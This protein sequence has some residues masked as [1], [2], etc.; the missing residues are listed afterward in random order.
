MAGMK[1]EDIQ[2]AISPIA[3]LAIVGD[4]D[5]GSTAD[6]TTNIMTSYETVSYTHL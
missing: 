1:V 4:T 2:Q 5:L 6:M 3:K